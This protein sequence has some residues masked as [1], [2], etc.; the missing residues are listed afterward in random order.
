[1]NTKA[2]VAVAVTTTTI[3]DQVAATRK[4]AAKAV[5]DVAASFRAYAVQ[6]NAM[7]GTMPSFDGKYWW[8]VDGNAKGAEFAPIHRERELFNAEMKAAKC[9]NVSTYASRVRKYGKEE[10]GLFAK[11]APAND[12]EG[13]EG[14]EGGAGNKARPIHG[15]YVEE[16]SALYK[17]RFS[18][19]YASE[20]TDA[21]RNAHKHIEQ[22]LIA[23]GID[24]NTLV[25]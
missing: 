15:R 8:D 22:A 11:D 24:V 9:T 21:V 16:L 18:E 10:S 13:G 20:M 6:L 2:K 25:K 4:A 23:L 17:A 19:M 1:M 7:F 14:A 12:A 3:S 5:G